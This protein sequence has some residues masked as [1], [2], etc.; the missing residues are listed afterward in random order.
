MKLELQKF[1]FED[2]LTRRNLLDYR[3]ALEY[4]KYR[5]SVYRNH[6]FELI[7]HTIVPYLDYAEMM[8][9]FIYSDYD[10]SLSFFDLDTTTDMMILWLDLSRYQI[11][12]LDNFLSGRL[13]DLERMYPNP[14]LMIPFA[15][16]FS[17]SGRIICYDLSPLEQELGERYL[18]QRL[19][20]FSGTKM[21]A[22][23]C[24]KVSRQLGLRYIP[25]LLRPALKAIVVDLDNTLYHGVLGEDGATSLLLTEGHRDLQQ[26]LKKLGSEGFFLCIASKNDMRDVV[27]MFDQRQDFP[28]RRDDFTKICANWNDK[29]HS[30]EEIACF[31]N[32]NPDSIL[33]IDDNIGE[34]AA[35]ASV[36]PQ[37]KQI[38]ALE[39]AAVTYEILQLYPGLL[40]LHAQ[41]ED[42]L[43]KNDVQ[44]NESRR[45]IQAV[46]SPEA[47][48][49]S[50]EMKVSFCIDN[51]DQVAR[52]AE[53][54]NKTNQFICSYRRYSLSDVIRLMQSPDAAVITAALLDKLSDSGIIGVCVALK[55]D[56]YVVV[57]ECFVSCRALGRGIDEILVLGM[58]RCALDYFKCE[59]LKMDF[60]KGERNE[61]AEKF[62]EGNLS[63][64]LQKPQQFDYQLPEGLVEI[65]MLKY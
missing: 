53:L 2:K 28:L 15:D 17:I 7:E 35:V 30:I 3:S 56:H 25:A 37:V 29:A 19:E 54:A 51:P 50:L 18:D 61:P 39:D 10:D 36:L 31:L 22:A 23:A 48:I 38:H 63:A 64:C 32:I 13:N 33:F 27:D 12:G 59:V 24:M 8:V 55:R 4:P 5:I 42:Q 9:E 20:A 46:L 11:D 45:Q 41:E 21:S 1:L 14:I 49:R 60:V 26:Y 34:L 44:A 40:R 65:R 52:I 62:V 58:M 47:Y 6:S 57:E 43:R 16:T